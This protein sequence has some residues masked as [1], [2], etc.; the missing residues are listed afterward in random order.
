[1]FAQ[2]QRAMPYVAH[3]LALQS[4]LYYLAASICWVVLSDDIAFALP[5]AQPHQRMVQTAKD[6][7]FIAVMAPGFYWF[8]LHAQR[9]LMR[10]PDAQPPP[11]DRRDRASADRHARALDRRGQTFDEPPPGERLAAALFGVS[12]EAL[13][14]TCARGRYLQVNKALERVSGYSEAEL[15]SNTPALLLARH[16]NE[17]A[18][19]AMFRTLA[20]D[21]TWTGELLA[22][23]KGGELFRILQTVTAVTD[24]EGKLRNYA[25]A[26]SDLS[27][28]RHLDERL[29]RLSRIDRL[30]GLPNRK[31]LEER[32][33]ALTD[34]ASVSGESLALVLLNYD[35]F[36]VVNE[37]LGAAEADRTLCEGA[38]RLT[39][40][41]DGSHFVARYG[42]ARFAVLAR[43][44]T[45][46]EALIELAKRCARLL[47]C[48]KSLVGG[49][50]INVTVSA[51]MSA[52]NPAQGEEGSL[53]NQAEA[54]LL[55]QEPGE[56][57]T[58]RFFSSEVAAIASRRLAVETGLLQA[59]LKDEFSVFLQPKWG[60]GTKS[61]VGAEA[62]LRWNSRELGPVSPDEFI[63]IAEQHPVILEL[64]RWMAAEI[65]RHLAHH[66]ER[67][68]GLQ[69][70]INLS[71]R[72]LEDLDFPRF[73][74]A[75]VADAGLVPS[76]LQIELT[77]TCLVQNQE[78][79][80][81]FLQELR[82]LG[83]S[84]ALDDFG[85]GY[86]SLAY[87]SQFPV[88]VVKL[89][90]RFVEQLPE[91]ETACVVASSVLE[92]ASRLQMLTVAEGVETE[93][94]RQFLAQAG[95]DQ[96]QGWLVCAA[97]PADEFFQ[98]LEASPAGSPIG[99]QA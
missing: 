81:T 64:G 50:E 5:L 15:L 38:A 95:C 19:A 4:A 55:L 14:L 20:H 60:I 68:P 63:P 2:Q 58:L 29:A 34:R 82:N 3:K 13:A 99:T 90:R 70:S 67:C 93:A 65:V 40:A 11:G 48:T 7:L 59:S 1:M 88:D 49:G 79:A 43:A 74:A 94:Q 98:R 77:E 92:M 26:F 18:L 56:R 17:A 69:I 39:E 41:L 27:Q 37:L 30:T 31:A 71:A 96:A 76:C 72:Q 12:G 36:P 53:I 6:L 47:D 78:D 80:R 23:R 8:L 35:R 89:D 73:I 32:V 86:S 45:S 54:A 83:F 87:L 42:A 62:L 33:Q 28:Q 24:S 9:S 61:T 46:R 66:R 22:K 52:A 84:V 57:N 85:A 21:G 44:D 91:N 75:L 51:G 97:L 10:A 25:V 16:H